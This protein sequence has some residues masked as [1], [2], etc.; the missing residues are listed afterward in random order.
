MVVSQLVPNISL[1]AGAGA[2]APAGGGFGGSLAAL[3]PFL[4]LQ[5]RAQQT[6][7]TA[8]T[9]AARARAGQIIAAAPDLGTGLQNLQKDPAM[10]YVPDV[11]N[12]LRQAQSF[13]VQSGGEIAKQ[14]RDAID[15][16]YKSAVGPAMSDPSQLDALTTAT[17]K[18][19]PQDMQERVAPA[20]QSARNALLDGF[21]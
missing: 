10:A 12:T 11:V 6:Q 19:L 5:Q 8:Q 15:A 4:E 14:N 1:G 16:Y 2:A 7:M 21:G 20:F 3:A 17:L 18:T 13:Q 9:M